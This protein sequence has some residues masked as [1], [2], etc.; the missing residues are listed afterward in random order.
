[1]LY[2]VLAIATALYIAFA[3]RLGE[4]YHFSLA[5]D[6]Y[7]YAL[8]TI[9]SVASFI[10]LGLYRAV[11]RYMTYQAIYTVVL[12]IVIS[13]VAL[14][15]SSFFTDSFMP[16]S[17][18]VIYVFAALLLVGFPRLIIRNL[19][20]ISDVMQG[21]KVIIY[22]AGVSGSQLAAALQLSPDY[23]PVAFIDDN[24]KLHNS[25][26]RGLN[27]FSF[28][29]LPKLMERY[30]TD[31]VLLALGRTPRAKRH[32]VVKMLETMPVQI[33]TV[34][35][36]AELLSGRANLNDIKDIEIEDLLGRDPSLPDYK[37]MAA[38]IKGKTVL[39][40]GAG[41]SIG[42]ELCQQIAQ[43][44][45]KALLMLEQNEYNLYRIN[46]ELR[47]YK[48][49]EEH[50]L[51]VKTILGSAADEQLIARVFRKNAV[52]TVYHA[53]AYK[54]VPMLED[55]KAE[56]LRNNVLSTWYTAKAAVEY[57]VDSFVLISSD[58]A[59]RPTNIM[60]A[61]KRIAELILQAMDAKQQ[62][63]RFCMVRFGNVLG[64]SG[65][66]VPHFKEQIASGGPITVT[67]PDITRYF[68]V[69]S[70]AVQLVIQAGAM[71]SGGDVFVLDMG[72]PVRISD[73]AKEMI[74]LSGLQL[75]D[76]H[77]PDGDVEIHYTG[78]RA[79]EKLY[80]ELLV[81]EECE[82]TRHPRIMRS[83]EEAMSWDEVN[84]FINTVKELDGSESNEDIASLLQASAIHFQ[85][86]QPL[87]P[88][89]RRTI[90]AICE[91]SLPAAQAGS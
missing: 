64:S 86:Q 57:R 79:G 48:L 42:S 59:V 36:M 40:T 26:V 50:P 58:K 78:L 90:Q 74:L 68:M 9:I 60:G 85:T 61:S 71:G 7:T 54:H 8:T 30:Q 62:H 3:I 87:T 23:Q 15:A 55:N 63:T 37:L 82:R 89:F 65:S 75:K 32:E 38:N 84:A 76:E 12:G 27:I 2:D 44:Q 88:Q 43:L 35:N 47:E 4:S 13:A 18:P 39:V 10:R 6:L 72:E 80:E 81:K 21:E 1:M 19:V 73:L 91:D 17:V 41:G 31:K 66:V 52:D 28:A 46:E 56:G 33:Q 67:H 83:C 25:S 77:N 51:L 29:S 24:K 70:E 49:D 53:A 34:P 5:A 11:L 14:I 22:G 69:T 16:R 45:P 20:Q